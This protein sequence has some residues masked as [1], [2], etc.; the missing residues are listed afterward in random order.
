MKTKSRQELV[1][2]SKSSAYRTWVKILHAQPFKPMPA[3]RTFHLD[4]ASSTARWA[5]GGSKDNLAWPLVQY[6]K[7][8]GPRL[9]KP[10]RCKLHTANYCKFVKHVVETRQRTGIHIQPCQKPSSSP[11]SL[12]KVHRPIPTFCHKH[13]QKHLLQTILQ[14]KV[15][16]QLGQSI[17][18]SQS[19]QPICCGSSLQT[20]CMWCRATQLVSK[21]LLWKDHHVLATF[22]TKCDANAVPTH[23][24]PACCYI[25]P[26]NNSKCPCH[27]ISNTNLYASQPLL[28]FICNN[29]LVNSCNWNGGMSFKKKSAT[30]K[31]S[32]RTFI[33]TVG[34]KN[35]KQKF[36]EFTFR[37]L[38]LMCLTVLQNRI[39]CRTFQAVQ[40]SKFG[41]NFVNSL[42]GFSPE[43]LP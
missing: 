41:Q 23:Q 3:T 33:S 39:M 5:A 10:G 19:E 12:P 6:Q 7:G 17:R 16:T 25:C 31:K 40:T 32:D 43:G 34:S 1:Y 36:N 21:Y 35:V 11:R 27:N 26:T 28:V 24:W 18:R 38:G 8:H 2:K 13:F 4:N 22:Q 20:L 15:E 9:F 29:A 14:H 37:W 42:L 30:W